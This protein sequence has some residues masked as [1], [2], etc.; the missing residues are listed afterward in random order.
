MPAHSLRPERMIQFCG[1]RHMQASPARWRGLLV[2]ACAGWL[3]GC[4][5][6]Q[7]QVDGVFA[8]AIADVAPAALRRLFEVVRLVGADIRCA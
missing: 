3:A 1:V 2:L 7:D 4:R 8:L 5:D 6:G